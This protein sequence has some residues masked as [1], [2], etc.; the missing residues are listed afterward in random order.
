MEK[1]KKMK[2]FYYNT[3]NFIKEKNYCSTV[4]YIKLKESEEL[5][6][7]VLL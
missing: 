1:K 3:L 6:K 5:C 7:Y 2:K 4:N